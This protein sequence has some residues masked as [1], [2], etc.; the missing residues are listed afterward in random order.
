[1]GKYNKPKNYNR[2][3]NLKMRCYN[4]N[5]RNYKWYGAK[6]VAMCD[7]WKN[8]YKAFEDWILSQPNYSKD[9]V[10]TR[11]GDTGNYEP[12]N[13]VLKTASENLKEMHIKNPNVI[14]KALMHNTKKVM[15]VE[16]GDIYDSAKE[17]ALKLNLNKCSVSDSANPKNRQKY[18][19]GYT[20]RYIEGGHEYVTN[21]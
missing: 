8:S 4:P 20:W 14:K 7:E 1:M 6:G 12:S 2:W 3:M 17:A 18:A 15:C 5:N 9:M 19:G 10:L 16:T 21:K 11:I 13:C